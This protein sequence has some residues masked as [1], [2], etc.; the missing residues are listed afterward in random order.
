MFEATEETIL[1]DSLYFYDYV[2]KV[3]GIDEENIII[4][5]RSIGTGPATHVASKRN[6]GCLI[7]MSAFKSIRSIAQD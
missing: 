6:P 1:D 2:N 7:L 4:F 5:G 3:L